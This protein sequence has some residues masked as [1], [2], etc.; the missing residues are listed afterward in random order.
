MHRSGRDETPKDML[1]G[2]ADIESAAPA[3]PGFSCPV[4]R[5]QAWWDFQLRDHGVLRALY[6]NFHEI[7][8]GVYRSSQPAPRQL[9]R[10][11][12]RRGLRAVLNLRGDKTASNYQFEREACTRL[13]LALHDHKL[14]A[15]RAASRAELLRLAALMRRIERPFLMHCKSGADRT[16]FAAA[17]YLVMIEGQPVETARRQL[18]WRYM[19]FRA[20]PAGI[21]DHFFDAY[22]A[23]RARC[24]ITLHDW[25]EYEYDPR[26]LAAGFARRR[27]RN[28]D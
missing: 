14:Q 27:V 10:Y 9:A 22:A 3:A 20:G 5:R 16:G 26:A 28:H 1:Q 4:A 2:R 13:G 21:L 11:C 6:A 7:A 23:A 15:R 18:H 25:I 12:R 8:P 19:H 24:G 17:L